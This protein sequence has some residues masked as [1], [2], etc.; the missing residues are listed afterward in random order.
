MDWIELYSNVAYMYPH[1]LN[2]VL[3]YLQKNIEKEGVFLHKAF[4]DE[5]L[6]WQWGDIRIVADH[7]NR[8]NI[9]SIFPP[10]PESIFLSKLIP[11]AYGTKKFLD[12]GVGTGILSIV[13]AKKGWKAI[14][15]DVNRRAINVTNINAL[16]NHVEV[17][18]SIDDLAQSQ[19]G[20]NIQLCIANLPFES[21][22]PKATNYIHSDGGE[23]GDN[24]IFPFLKI[25]PDILVAGG[26]A[27]VPS[28]SL[29][30]S[31]KSR[32]EK[33][34]LHEKHTLF[35]SMLFR[36]SKPIDIQ[37]LYIKYPTNKWRETYNKLKGEGYTHFTID[38]AILKRITEEQKPGKFLGVCEAI[39]ADKMWIMPQGWDG[40]GQPLAL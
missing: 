28:F 20:H 16:L 36:L 5:C 15:V 18:V 17:A 31:G 32:I 1:M 21:T 13:A 34:L 38:F 10:H 25:V 7:P 39:V 29:L 2:V 30:K 27:V 40:I 23:Y 6:V 22:P 3:Q 9:D 11:D 37:S 35:H 24:L 14:G 19:K 4:V 33:E 12:V 8:Q 26:V